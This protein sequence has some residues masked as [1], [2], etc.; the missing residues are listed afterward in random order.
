MCREKSDFFCQEEKKDCSHFLPSTRVI[1]FPSAATPRRA[2]CGRPPPLRRFT[3]LERRFYVLARRGRGRVKR[4]FNLGRVSRLQKVCV[5]KKMSK[6]S[7]ETACKI[8]T[9]CAPESSHRNK[10]SVAQNVLVPRGESIKNIEG[11]SNL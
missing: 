8:I 4:I 2:V 10:R 6:H 7:K 3:F 5:P 9:C 11:T 1:H